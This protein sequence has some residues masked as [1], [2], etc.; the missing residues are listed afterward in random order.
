MLARHGIVLSV[1]STH[2]P[3]NHTA[4]HTKPAQLP[5]LAAALVFRGVM[6]RDATHAMDAGVVVRSRSVLKLSPWCGHIVGRPSTVDNRQCECF[7]H[8]L[9][10]RTGV[11][12][13]LS[14]GFTINSDGLI[15]CADGTVDFWTMK[16]KAATVVFVKF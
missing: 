14:L 7:Y 1:A 6:C 12:K 10:S 13:T 5:L 4:L 2:Q 8:A 16:V 15:L 3:R 9:F 11:A